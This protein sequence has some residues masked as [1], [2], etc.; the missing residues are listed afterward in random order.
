MCGRF[1][2]YQ[3]SDELA[4]RFS[5][6]VNDEWLGPRYNVAPSQEIAVV[7]DRENQR[8]LE[9]LKWGLAPAWA[10]RPLI[11]IRADTLADPSK[12]YFRTALARRRCVIPASGFYEW[13]EADNPR[14]G[15]KTPIYFRP[16]D[17][18]I[19]A[20]AGVWDGNT[21][22][23]I[24]TEPNSLAARVHNRMPVILPR[25]AETAWLD[26][27]LTD[28]SQ[29]AALLLPYAGRMEA[30][31]VSCAVNRAGDDD[32]QFIVPTGDRLT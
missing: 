3:P 19:L 21:C 10:K 28:A 17:E 32:P 16:L 8:H 20:F 6:L 5:T 18:A 15:G 12:G 9:S 31:P 1:T 26:P 30:Y 13:M 14:E 7:R 22:A 23:I 25:E 29:A 2:L 24:T 11:N 27:S 4:E